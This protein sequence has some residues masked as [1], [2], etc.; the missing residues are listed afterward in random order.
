MIRGNK[1]GSHAPEDKHKSIVETPYGRATVLRTRLDEDD[2][3]VTMRELELTDWKTTASATS[4]SATSASATA[5]HS[6]EASQPQQPPKDETSRGPVRPATLF[7]PKQYPSV[8]PAVGDDVICLYG[9]G[10]VIQVRSS[11]SSSSTEPEQGPGPEPGQQQQQV[12]V[13]LSSWRLAGRS[14]ITCYLSV[15]AVQ[16]VRSKKLYEMNVYER[17]EFAQHLKQTTAA[18][19]FSAKNYGAA[20]QTYAAAVDALRYVQ[21]TSDSSNEVR[22]DLVVLMITCSNNA[23][24]C[25]TKLLH[26]DEAETF[27]RNT[28]II[29][30]ALEPKRGKRIHVLLNQ[31]GYTDVKMF[32]EWKVK[33]C[34]II[35][36]ALAEK[37][38]Y[39]EAM[40]ILKTAREVIDKYTVAA[41]AAEDANQQPQ[42]P[43][44]ALNQQSVKT[45]IANGK[46]IKKLHTQCKD[47]RKVERDKEKKRAR[48]MFGGG[49]AGGASPSP[50]PVSEEK[51]DFDA[52]ADD[53]TEKPSQTTAA[54]AAV[55][56]PERHTVI[57]TATPESLD[58]MAQKKV[59]FS[60]D[61]D[62][63]QMFERDDTAKSVGEE[64]EWYQDTEVLAGLAMFAGSLGLSV[65]ALNFALGGR[66][67]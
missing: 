62:D 67:Q 24:T 14:L 40:E 51:K 32:G 7:S 58:G 2:G 13:R 4:A 25:C 5:A 12:V 45:L 44:V 16:V 11:S 57:G 52:D 19:D 65:L 21:H 53:L 29:I 22:A 38:D 1:Y 61:P 8:L 9:R 47:R 48:A 46:E 31:S 37:G 43:V 23:A 27:A 66:R 54:A 10:K 59:S 55:A 28:L 6:H 60:N 15:H 26:W 63:V 49:G 34:I 50:S 17:V 42:Q 30:D 18:A 56:A 35:A 39:D 33:S 3:S 41:A 64:P 36:K 20:L